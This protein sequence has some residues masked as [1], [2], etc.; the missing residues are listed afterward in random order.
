MRLRRVRRRLL[1]QAGLF[2]DPDAYTAGVL[3][4][5]EACQEQWE[6]A[7]PRSGQAVGSRAEVDR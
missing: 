4:A 2:D 3:D 1:A 6:R 7:R 5:L